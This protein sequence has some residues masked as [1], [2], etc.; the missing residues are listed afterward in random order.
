MYLFG[1]GGHCKAIIDM[2]VSDLKLNISGIYDDSQN[3]RKYLGLSHN[4]N[5]K[6]KAFL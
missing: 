4:P 6:I 3:N 2:I 1:A 5:S